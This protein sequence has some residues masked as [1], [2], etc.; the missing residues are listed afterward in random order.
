MSQPP[1]YVPLE[2]REVEQC[3][4]NRLPARV[5]RPV[6]R[7]PADAE[8]QTGGVCV[9]PTEGQPG[10]LFYLL[11]G[12][13]YEQDAGA[14]DETLAALIPGSVLETVPGE[15]PAEV[16]P[17]PYPSDPPWDPPGLRADAPTE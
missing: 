15:I 14:V 12:L 6:L 2:R 5:G 8:T 16:P 9:F 17:S 4:G 10:W 3:L 7:V 1:I 13:I 11:D